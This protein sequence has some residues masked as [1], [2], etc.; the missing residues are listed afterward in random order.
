M[1]AKFHI[2]GKCLMF[3]VLC[4]IKEVAQKCVNSFAQKKLCT[5]VDKMCVGLRFRA[6]FS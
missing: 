4:T 2:L 3:N 6:I 5:N 1:G